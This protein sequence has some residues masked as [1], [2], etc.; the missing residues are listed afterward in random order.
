MKMRSNNDTRSAQTL[1]LVL[2]VLVA[3]VLLAGQ[4]AEAKG[5]G[6]GGG[7]GVGGGK[8]SISSPSRPSGSNSSRPSDSSGSS[9]GKMSAGKGLP[10]GVANP[11]SRYYNSPRYGL[12]YGSLSNFFLWY[13]IFH[14]NDDRYQE[15]YVQPNYGWGGWILMG[16]GVIAVAGIAIW[17]LRRRSKA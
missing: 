5:A 11:A 2:L 16:L 15:E 14:H 1:A 7:R 13:W 9:A 3:A 6:G 10:S 12:R 8:P 17:L 4:V